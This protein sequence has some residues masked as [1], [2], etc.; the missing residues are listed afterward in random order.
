[1]IFFFFRFALRYALWCSF[2]EV[3]EWRKGSIGTHTFSTQ[4]IRSNQVVCVEYNALLDD[5]I[6]ESQLR[7][8]FFLIYTDLTIRE[9]WGNWEYFIWPRSQFL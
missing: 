1:M 6:Q 7:F 5:F 8:Y 3:G 4:S 9:V 2:V